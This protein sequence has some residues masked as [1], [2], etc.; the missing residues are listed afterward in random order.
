M[1]NP[2]HP[3][4]AGYATTAY[5]RASP[6]GG[7]ATQP[8]D[9]IRSLGLRSSGDAAEPEDRNLQSF[10]VA[11]QQP[12]GQ[13]SGEPVSEK[14]AVLKVHPWQYKQHD[15]LRQLQVPESFHG[16]RYH[17]LLAFLVTRHA[18]L[19]LALYRCKEA[20]GAP[21]PYVVTNPSPTL[22]LHRKDR[23]FVL[24]GKQHVAPAHS[25]VQK[26]NRPSSR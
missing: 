3:D 13:P 24:C 26:A 8:Q 1:K 7:N 15:M 11:K 5:S 25:S 12:I 21:M 22:R 4:A 14:Q 18:I 17:S 16:R 23:L 2:S 20:L 6:A 9:S 19:P 10:N